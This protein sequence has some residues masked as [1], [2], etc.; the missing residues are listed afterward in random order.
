MKTPLFQLPSQ[1][2]LRGRRG[3]V[4]ARRSFPLTDYYYQSTAKAPAAASTLNPTA[5]T[6]VHVAEI[7]SFRRLSSTAAGPVSRRQFAADAIVLGLVVA[8]VI[9]PLLSLLIVM[10][11]TAYGW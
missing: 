4:T 5:I 6:T 11:E 8:V 2:S 10:S 1:F 9:W 7:R 3:A